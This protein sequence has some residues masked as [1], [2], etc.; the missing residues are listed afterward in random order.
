MV[1]RI[2]IGAEVFSLIEWFAAPVERTRQTGTNL[3]PG[4][5]IKPTACPNLALERSDAI[6]YYSA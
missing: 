2:V 3:T 6:E 4:L 1:R 5:C